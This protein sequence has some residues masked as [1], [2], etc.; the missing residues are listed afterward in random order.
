IVRTIRREPSPMSYPQPPQYG[1]PAVPQRKPSRASAVTAGVLGMI[2]AANVVLAVLPGGPIG[3]R[4]LLLVVAV[5]MV[6]GSVVLLAGKFTGVVVFAG[7][8]G[9]YLFTLVL[10]P[11]LS[12]GDPD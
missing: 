10:Q 2:A 7:A 1:P 6:T 5:T 8:T 11:I 4:S 12:E 3:I 9:V